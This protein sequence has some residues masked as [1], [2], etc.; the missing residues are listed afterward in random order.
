MK[1]HMIKNAEDFSDSPTLKAIQEKSKE[2]KMYTI[3]TIPRKH[4]GKLCN[5]AFVINPKGELHAQYN[6]IHLFDI[7][8]PGKITYY[9]S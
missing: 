8:I 2:F 9:E 1:D 6:K 5:T 7:N 4:E 3:G